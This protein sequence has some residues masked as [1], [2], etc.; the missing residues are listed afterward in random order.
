[1]TVTADRDETPAIR[2]LACSRCHHML[3]DKRFD[4]E[5]RVC[6]ECGSH[7][8]LDAAHR[9][10][11]LFD[12]GG[13]EVVDLPIAP[14]DCLGF[15]DSKPYIQRISD[16]QAQT[17]MRTAVLCARGAVEG[18]EIVAAIMDF[19]FLGGSL[20]GAAGEVI[21]VAAEIALRDRIP[22][23]IVSASGGARMQEG[24]VSLMQM[25][26]TNQAL[27][28][29]NEAGV[30]TLSLIT[31]PTYG[32]VAASYATACD[33]V[34]A[35][36]G[37]RMGFAGPRVIEQTIGQKLPP[38]FQTA[39]ALLAQGF[40]D[41]IVPRSE[42]RATIGRLLRATGPDGLLPA[43]VEHDPVVRDPAAL[44]ERSPWESVELARDIRRPT[45][46]DYITHIVTGFVELHGD[47]VS[48]DCAAVVGGVGR[49]GDQPIMLIGHQKGHSLEELAVRNFAMP[50]PAGYRKATRLMRL[51]GKLGLPVVTFIDTPGAYPGLEAERNGQANAIS[52]SLVMMAR[53]PVPVVAVVTGEGGS[54]GAL[55]LAVANTVL[56][57]SN[58]IYS[59]I[60][61]E[62]CAA[63]LWKDR[64]AAPTAAGQL[65]LDARRLLDQH[66]VDGVLP[67]P[68]GGAQHDHAE[69]SAVLNA[70]VVHALRELVDLTPE[71]LR[72][73]RRARF[74]KFG[75]RPV[76][77]G[78]GS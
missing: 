72:R 27:A 69:M 60:S 53:L 67:E 20:G 78:V 25:A 35:E 11:Q 2:W 14:S 64:A 50:S 34:L 13:W 37:A 61:P 15:I 33:V 6:P 52:E 39:E 71:C 68:D 23:L 32:G 54:G 38:G 70:G 31:D 77:D 40:I 22:L 21:T 10:A 47:R 19:R 62:G 4:R 30:L 73:E 44:A 24:A 18:S 59:V 28:E 49:L 63:I 56:M 55:A 29:L 74:R 57:C 46:L 76:A 17:G 66:I 65:G 42:L 45:T 48:G 16:A 7:E 58:G 8:R 43:V 9:A 1:M 36:P 51:A 41:G 75:R 26:K 3:Y 5:L 12:P